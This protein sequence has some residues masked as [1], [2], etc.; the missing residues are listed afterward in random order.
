M[1][2]NTAKICVLCLIASAH[3]ASPLH[4][5]TNFYGQITRMWLNGQKQEVLSI[6]TNRLAANTND[7]AGLVMKMSYELA[8]S[9]FSNYT[10]T[11]QRLITVGEKVTSTNF[12]SLYFIL[13]LERDGM[14]QFLSTV[15]TNDVAQW[16][17]KG[18]IT[19][20]PMTYRRFLE[21][22][23]ADGLLGN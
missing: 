9:D 19:N 20:K 13:P 15:T 14:N 2:T 8:F 23:E 11:L 7:L 12:A 6:A 4:A 17:Q 18:S 22:I 10:N 21:A 3:V 5:Q 1:K 16:V